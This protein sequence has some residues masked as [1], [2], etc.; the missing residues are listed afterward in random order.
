MT[1]QTEVRVRAAEVARTCYGRLVALLAATTGDL[2]LAEDVLEDAFERA[3][4]T[5]PTAGVPDNPEAWL[6]TVARNRL[7]DVLASAAART[8]VPSTP[9]TADWP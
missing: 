4:R 7:R 3:L 5:W 6:L 9:R 8:S 1:G 2:A